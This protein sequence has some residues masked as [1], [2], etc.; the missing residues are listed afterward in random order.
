[1]VLQVITETADYSTPEQAD[2]QEW[3]DSYGLTM[4]VLADA[5]GMLWTYAEG[6]T[7]VGLPFTVVLDR[8]VLID[9]IAS[10]SNSTRAEELL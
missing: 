5:E 6:M 4:P 2:L 8:G 1:M 3:A 10:G 9:T 7:S